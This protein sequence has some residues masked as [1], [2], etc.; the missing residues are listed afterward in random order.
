[1]AIKMTEQE[2]CPILGGYRCSFVMDSDSDASKLP[3]CCPGSTAVVAS[4]GGN[5]Y[6]VNAS[7]EWA[8]M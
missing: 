4:S 3:D 6:M 2:W 5:I 8:V 7:G 1:M